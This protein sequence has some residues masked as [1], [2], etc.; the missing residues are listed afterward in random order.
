MKYEMAS[1]THALGSESYRDRFEAAFV[2][3]SCDDGC[4]RCSPC[5]HCKQRILMMAQNRHECPPLYLFDDRNVL[6]VAFSPEDAT[7][8]IQKALGL[9]PSEIGEWEQVEDGFEF[10]MHDDEGG[11]PTKLTAQEWVAQSGRGYLASR[12]R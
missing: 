5:P 11:E 2:L 10:T 1:F 7:H 12:E 4:D 8:L 6:V 9:D 3:C